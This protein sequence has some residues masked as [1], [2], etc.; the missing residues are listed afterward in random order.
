L[1]RFK[2]ASGASSDNVRSE[3]K[4]YTRY[5]LQ[6]EDETKLAERTLRNMLRS[7]SKLLHESEK[8]QPRN[9]MKFLEKSTGFSG[10][11]EFDNNQVPPLYPEES[12]SCWSLVVVTLTAT[13]L[14]LPNIENGHVKGFLA[15]MSEGLKY[16]RHIEETLNANGELV[17]ARKT[18]RRIWTEAE[19]HCSWLE[20]ELQKKPRNEKSSKEIL[21]WLGDEAEQIVIQFKRSKKR[22]VD[23]SLHKFIAASS[24]YRISQ[25]ILLHCTEQ[26]IW[27]T[28]W[29]LFEWISTVI[30]DLL[31]ACFTNLPR[32]IA[33]KCHHNAIE[34]RGESIRTATR[35]LGECQKILNIL[36]ERQLPD[37]D[38][39]SMAYIDKWHALPQS[40]IPNGRASSTRIQSSSSSSNESVTVSVI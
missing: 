40:L 10:V 7:I 29:E 36:E 38:R 9:L 28:N 12:H 5:V 15:S 25:T 39:E 1:K 16:V 20:I 17:Q 6:I 14:A 4:E 3:I 18:A 30:A 35:L 34:K 11:I 26:E 8:K 33:L 19:V 24:M 21:R 2:K 13:A 23:D 27:P 22:S 37:L 32:V 31:W